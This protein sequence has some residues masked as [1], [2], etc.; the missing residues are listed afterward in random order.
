M[1]FFKRR[2]KPEKETQM[3]A[4]LRPTNLKRSVK[5]QLHQ[6]HADHANTRPRHQRVRKWFQQQPDH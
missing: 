4:T 3:P 5:R 1:P 2:Q 6:A